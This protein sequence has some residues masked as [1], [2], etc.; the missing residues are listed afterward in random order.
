MSP[1]LGLPPTACRFC[2][3]SRPVSSAKWTATWGCH[4]PAPVAVRGHWA[5]KRIPEPWFLRKVDSNILIKGI[6][7]LE[8]IGTKIRW[9]FPFLRSGPR[10]PL[11]NHGGI[12]SD[13]GVWSISEFRDPVL[14]K[15]LRAREPC[16]NNQTLEK[17]REY[18]Y[19]ILRRALGVCLRVRKSL[20]VAA[21]AGRF[22]LGAPPSTAAGLRGAPRREQGLW[23]TSVAFLHHSCPN[24][25]TSERMK[26]FRLGKIPS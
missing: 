2:H 17:L 26:R 14:E 19:W 21:R 3:Y 7:K 18:L 20:T 22:G 5:A 12:S 1:P 16:V 8:N 11:L 6:P 15:R 4:P 10:G 23:P 13:L 25:R 9:R 24:K